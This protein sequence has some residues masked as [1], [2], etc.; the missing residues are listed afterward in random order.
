MCP[1]QEKHLEWP[2]HCDSHFQILSLHERRRFSFCSLLQA[3][4]SHG[5]NSKL[6]P[7]LLTELPSVHFSQES[8]DQKIPPFLFDCPKC[9]TAEQLLRMVH[10]SMLSVTTHSWFLRANVGLQS[11]LCIELRIGLRKWH[12]CHLLGIP[13]H[14]FMVTHHGWYPNRIYNGI[15]E[16]KFGFY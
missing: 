7:I 11:I 13:M 14:Y 16:R 10:G 3:L 2:E 9:P 12:V 6:L 5:I 4:M 15:L 1:A 8:Q